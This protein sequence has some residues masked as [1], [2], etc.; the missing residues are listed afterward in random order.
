[1]AVDAASQSK[2]KLPQ[3]RLGKTG[4]R[5]SLIG[6][7]TGT[8]GGGKQSN[9]TRLGQDRFTAMIQHAYERGITFLDCADQYGSNPYMGK[10]IKAIG[11]PR[12]NVVIQT[13]TNSR[14]PEGVRADIERFLNEFETDYIDMVLLHCMMQTDWNVALR[15]AMDVMEEL[16]RK[17]V[18]RAHGVSCHHFGALETAASEKW[19]DVDLARYNPWGSHMDVPPG[20]T[21]Q[22]SPPKVREVLKKMKDAGKGVIG[23]KVLAEGRMAKGPDKLERA[24][25]SIKFTLDS[26]V[27]DLM[28][29]GFESE[30]QIDEIVGQTWKVLEAKGTR[31]SGG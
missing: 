22:S 21:A 20:E 6:I 2:K 16:K 15:G 18:I 28:V 23:M 30:Q 8:V 12:K 9:Q 14:T 17:K 4:I 1:G 24:Y 19:V 7:G 25:E 3:V 31:V 10:A 29:V 13:K 26:G 5:A 27:I 11:I